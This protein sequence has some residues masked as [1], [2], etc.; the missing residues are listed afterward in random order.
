MTLGYCDELTIEA[1]EQEGIK[2]EYRVE[3]LSGDMFV[4]PK[5]IEDRELYLHHPIICPLPGHS[6][7]RGSAGWQFGV[8]MGNTPLASWQRAAIDDSYH[9]LTYVFPKEPGHDRQ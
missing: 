8:P 2:W 7:R 5:G 4:V 6:N 9:A 3:P 1:Y